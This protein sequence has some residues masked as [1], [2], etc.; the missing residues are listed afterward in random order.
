MKIKFRQ[1]E[2]DIKKQIRDFVRKIKL[3]NLPNLIKF[4]WKQDR[5]NELTLYTES[6]GP[7]RA[8]P[9]TANE[10]YGTTKTEWQRLEQLLLDNNIKP[11]EEKL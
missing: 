10:F 6:I 9:F 3:N 1:T 4:R 2:M 5:D 8:Q 7:L 11:Y